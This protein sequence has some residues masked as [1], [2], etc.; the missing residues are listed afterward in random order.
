MHRLGDK[1]GLRLRQQSLGRLAIDEFAADLQHHWNRQWRNM[2]ERAIDNVV[3]DP[4]Q[5]GRTP[6]VEQPRGRFLPGCA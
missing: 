5:H 3:L 4:C 1:I 6:D 2:I